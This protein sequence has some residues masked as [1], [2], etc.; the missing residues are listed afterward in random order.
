MNKK[1]IIILLCVIFLVFMVILFRDNIIRFQLSTK[2]NYNENV[3]YITIEIYDDRL[4]KVFEGKPD[5]KTNDRGRIYIEI[6]DK[7]KIEKIIKYLN[8]LSL[9][10]DTINEYVPFDIDNVGYFTIDITKKNSEEYLHGFDGF[11]FYTNYMEFVSEGHDHDGIRYYIKNSG[12]NSTTKSSKTF[13]FLYDL[14][15][16][17]E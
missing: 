9:M 2:L 5:I 11:A 13:K 1:R 17:S 7:K 16:E 14:I 12:Y 4:T 6:Y 15:N 8:S 10:D 3:D